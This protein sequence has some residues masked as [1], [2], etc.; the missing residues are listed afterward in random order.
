MR[1]AADIEEL[2]LAPAGRVD[3]RAF[4]GLVEAQRAELHAHCYRMLGSLHDADDALQDTLLRAWRALP[5]FRGQSSLRTWL[6]R[7]ATN[8][9]LD[10]IARRPKRVLPIDYGPATGPGD[11]EPAEPLSE[12]MWIEPYPDETLG[13][14]DGDAA[15]D[16]SY[17]RR[18]ALELAFIAALQHLPA[19][20][21][22]VLILRDVLGFS[23]KETSES[24]DTTVASV[25][26]ALQRARRAVDERVPERSQQ[27]TLRR[28]GD[29]RL[30]RLVERFADAFERGEINAILAMLTEDATFGMPPYPRLY[31]GREA[32]A[33]SWLMPG[34]PPPRLRYVP[35]RAN[36]QLA[37]GTYVLDRASA[38]YVPLALDVLTLRGDLIADV[39]A[40]RTPA[41]FPRFGLPDRLPEQP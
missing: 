39:T 7:I 19:R 14:A 10:A 37:L 18:E 21:R 8:V 2:Q 31:R 24:L 20:Q 35:T 6:Y 30:R 41:V 1:A 23:A 3:E 29:R 15:P 40:F 27:A 36:G 13:V 16:A 33:D 34:G 26:G 17:E 5:N 9:C 28:L 11:D 22:A 12:T 4:R 25:N 38:G 32:I